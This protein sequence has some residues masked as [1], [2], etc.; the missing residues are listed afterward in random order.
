M[1]ETYGPAIETALCEVIQALDG[2]ISAEPLN[3]LVLRAPRL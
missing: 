1:L 2:S 3:V